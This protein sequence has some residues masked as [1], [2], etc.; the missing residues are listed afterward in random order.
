MNAPT[1]TPETQALTTAG[2][3]PEFPIEPFR[4]PGSTALILDPRHLSQM[5][6]VADIMAKGKATVPSHLRGNQGDCLAV[7]MQATQWGMNPFAVAQKTHVVNGA[8]GYEAQLVNAVVNTMAPTKDRLNYE[9]FGEW[10]RVMGKFEER[11]SKKKVDEDT[12]KPLKYRVP[13]WNIADEAGLGVRVWATMKGEDQPR[14][15]ELL[16]VQCRVRN[17][18]LWADDPRQ[19]IAY[20][21]V[22]RWTRLHCPDVLLGVYTPDELDEALPKNMGS[23]EVVGPTVKPELLARAEAAAATGR[24]TYQEFWKHCTHGERAILS[25]QTDHHERLKNVAA[26]ADDNRTV[27]AGPPPAPTPAPT[28]GPTAASADPKASAAQDGGG[29][30]KATFANV[31]ER[32]KKASEEKNAIALDIAGD[33]IGEI[34]DPQQ[35]KELTEHY[36]AFK[37]AIA[38][39]SQQ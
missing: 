24:A 16:L 20:L 39:G 3:R 22:K 28:P 14:V 34:E 8:L 36:E 1:R 7:V 13:A 30:F 37:A 11:E 23:A 33:W 17:S 4:S 38:G 21:A 10:T 18:P 27:T 32:M 19:Q 15:L 26:A 35:R 31:Y 25:E 2:D 9:W 12:G 5:V 29:D 6:A